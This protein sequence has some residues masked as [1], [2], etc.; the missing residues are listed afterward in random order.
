MITDA[1]VYTSTEQFK[2]QSAQTLFLQ[3]SGLT[4]ELQQLELKQQEVR[5]VY[6]TAEEEMERIGLSRDIMAREREILQLRRQL[7]HAVQVNG[8]LLS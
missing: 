1:L 4:D 7:D 5:T 6:N 8:L 3:W 2:S